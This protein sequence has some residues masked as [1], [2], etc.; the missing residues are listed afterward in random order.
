[1]YQE[2]VSRRESDGSFYYTYSSDDQQAVL[3]IQVG[4]AQN[5]SGYS[6]D[7]EHLEHEKITFNGVPAYYGHGTSEAG[8]EITAQVY[9]GGAW[10]TIEYTVT[11]KT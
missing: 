8:D 7:N 2:E 10:D 5:G 6:L 4:I 3:D 11:A 1:M 9:S